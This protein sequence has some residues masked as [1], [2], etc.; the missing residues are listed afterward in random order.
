MN[1]NQVLRPALW[2]FVLLLP[3]ASCAE[4]DRWAG[5]SYGGS[6]EDAENRRRAAARCRDYA[7]EQRVNVMQVISSRP[8]GSGNDYEVRL[9][10]GR[11]FGTDEVTCYTDVRTGSTRLADM[12]SSGGPGDDRENRRRAESRCR[13]YAESQR[14]NVL[15]VMSSEA[16]GKGNDY[17][18]RLRV[19][20][21]IGLDEVTCY[22][23]VRTGSTRI[24][25]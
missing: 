23:D 12:P 21:G 15:Q 7:D 25:D 11:G 3:I 6:G 16:R 17:E 2:F 20:R 13:D 1:L 8:L 19:R 14:L 4:I 9:R 10:V 24:T 18:V 22:T 5:G